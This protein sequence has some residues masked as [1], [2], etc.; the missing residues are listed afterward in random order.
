VLPAR[1]ARLCWHV[2][3]L[4]GSARGR[5]DGLLCHGE[6]RRPGGHVRLVR[7]VQRRADE[8]CRARRWPPDERAEFRTGRILRL[9]NFGQKRWRSKHGGEPGTGGTIG[10]QRE[11]GQF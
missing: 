9:S 8:S 6:P 2:R 3:G 4:A 10:E 11:N 5:F 7:V 1:T